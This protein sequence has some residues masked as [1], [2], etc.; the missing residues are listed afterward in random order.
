MITA[1][2]CKIINNYSIFTILNI[3]II[4]LPDSTM[5]SQAILK[6]EDSHNNVSL[7]IF[8]N[9]LTCVY[10]LP[11]M[12]ACM[13]DNEPLIYNYMGGILHVLIFSVSARIWHCLHTVQGRGPF[14]DPLHSGP[15]TATFHIS[16]TSRPESTPN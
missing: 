6:S 14:G 4:L 2:Y 7:M 8:L 5:R 13:H 15:I 1:C 10:T 16:L 3:T 9:I 12:H 11:L